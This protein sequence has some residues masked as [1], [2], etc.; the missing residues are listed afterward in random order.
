MSLLFISSILSLVAM[1]LP[2]IKLNISSGDEL[3]NFFRD[4]NKLISSWVKLS[5][6][7]PLGK[8]LLINSWLTSQ[9]PFWSERP[10]S[11]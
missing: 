6:E 4:I 7:I 3:F 10:G 11:Q 2:C 8:T 1:S 9:E 5:K